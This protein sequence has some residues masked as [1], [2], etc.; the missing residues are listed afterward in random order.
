MR[1]RASERDLDHQTAVRS[2]QSLMKQCRYQV[3][4]VTHS[5][6]LQSP[7]WELERLNSP[8]LVCAL[9]AMKVGL[10]KPPMVLATHGIMDR[11]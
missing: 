4:I 9:L 5:S 11:N 3:A 2:Q 7:L 6:V 1:R 8:S 10:T